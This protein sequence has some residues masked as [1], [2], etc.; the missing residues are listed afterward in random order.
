[1][2]DRLRTGANSCTRARTRVGLNLHP[3]VAG[4]DSAGTA[5]GPA[6]VAAERRVFG[7]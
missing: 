5:F 2:C 6:D 4:I 3:A 1:M 7:G